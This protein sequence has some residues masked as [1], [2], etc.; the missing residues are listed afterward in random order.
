MQG[1]ELER[2]AELADLVEDEMLAVDGVETVRSD[3]V[4]GK[5][6]LRGG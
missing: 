5:T 4:A 6:E 3:W 1:D 2:L